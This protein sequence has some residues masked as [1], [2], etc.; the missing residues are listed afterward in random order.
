MSFVTES[1]LD[2][3]DQPVASLATIGPDGR[4]QVTAVWFMIDDDD[5]VR[6]SFNTGRQKTKNLRARPQA[7]FFLLDPSGYRYVEVR[8]DVTIAPDDDLT[9]AK[10]LSAKYGGSEF[11][12]RDQAGERRVVVS[13][14]PVRVNTWG[15]G[16]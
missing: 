11:W 13:L 7:T 1:V 14:S 2:L 5:A 3:F 12:Q 8:G 4:P 6:F 16:D 10:R 15:D 9:F